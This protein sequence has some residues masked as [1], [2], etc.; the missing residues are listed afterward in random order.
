MRNREASLQ[1]DVVAWMRDAIPE[2]VTFAILNDGLFSKRE[3]AK[4][5]WM[6]LL[7]GI[8]DI[9]IAYRSQAFF[10]EV[11]LPGARPSDEQNGVFARLEATSVRYAVVTS[12]DDARAALRGWGFQ[13][14]E[15]YVP[16]FAQCV[17]M[18]RA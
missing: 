8:P 1:A 18:R 13:F 12:L 16:E 2:A 7:P 4:R 17:I 10:M 9:G 6:G 3:A 15:R 11:K 5:K 14:D